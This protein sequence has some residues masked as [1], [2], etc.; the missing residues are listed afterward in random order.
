M[1]GLLLARMRGPGAPP[2][3][4][5]TLGPAEAVETVLPD[6]PLADPGRRPGPED[7][8]GTVRLDELLRFAGRFFV[9]EGV[10]HAVIGATAMSFWVPPRNTVDLDVMVR[11]DK[12]RTVTVMERLRKN[13]FPVTKRLTQSLLGGRMIKIPL[14]DTE[15]DL[16]LCRTRHDQES[17]ARAKT[18]RDAGGELRITVP[19]DLIIFKLQSWRR[20]DQADIERMLRQRKDLDPRY[21]EA[22]LGPVEG[23]TGHP[24][25]ERWRE[26]RTWVSR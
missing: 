25:Q 16:R 23:E 20:Q 4:L 17:M 10:D 5:G 14:G 22:W 18:F 2:A 15:L 7:E 8:A 12:H 9:E 26:A 13:K 11:A 24:V 21:I 1:A 19:E 6:V 3:G